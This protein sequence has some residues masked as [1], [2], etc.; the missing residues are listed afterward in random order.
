ME[1][2]DLEMVSVDPHF[3]IT[4][5]RTTQ[6]SLVLGSGLDG[7][8]EFNLKQIQKRDV[9]QWLMAASGGRIWE[10]ADLSS[11]VRGAQRGRGRDKG[12][13]SIFW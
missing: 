6:Y 4:K 13:I 2:S 11:I 10:E 1:W 3:K 12:V 8:F 9:V 5:Y 7:G